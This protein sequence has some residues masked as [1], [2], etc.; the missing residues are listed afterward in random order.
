M[1]LPVVLCGYETSSFILIEE[2]NLRLFE[3]RV[4]RKLLSPKEDEVLDGWRNVHVE[5]YDF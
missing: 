4:Q 3:N 1:I 5:F 2:N